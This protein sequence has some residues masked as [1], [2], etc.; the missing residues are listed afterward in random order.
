ML[1]LWEGDFRSGIVAHHHNLQYG[2]VD[3]NLVSIAAGPAA[4]GFDLNFPITICEW[5]SLGVTTGRN[6]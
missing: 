3:L 2:T 4:S 5:L 1:P 6:H